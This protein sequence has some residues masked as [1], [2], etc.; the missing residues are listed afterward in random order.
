MERSIRTS[1]LRL[2]IT[3]TAAV[4]VAQQST[5]SSVS[6][7]RLV[8]YSGRALDARDKPI[9]GVVGITFAI[10][11]D[12]ESGAA[13]WRETQ[14]VRADEKGNYT[15]QIGVTKSQGLPFELF[16]TN[17]S[18]WLGARVSG[19]QEQRRVLLLS[20]PYALKAADA[21]TLG[22]FP[23]SAFVLAAPVSQASESAEG[24]S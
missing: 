23:A 3:L 15:A 22:G 2:M 7:P 8:S 14:N 24:S 4:A 12:E 13:L 11:R 10:Y 9:S 1:R 21:E 20:V 16:D 18:R 19:Q 17:E 5:Q 6:V